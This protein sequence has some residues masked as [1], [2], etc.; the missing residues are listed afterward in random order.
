MAI[1]CLDCFY[2]WIIWW[3]HPYHRPESKILFPLWPN[4]DL[5]WHTPL[6]QPYSVVL[7]WPDYILWW[8]PH[9]GRNVYYGDTPTM[10]RP[11][12][13]VTPTPRPD[14][15]IWWHPY[16]GLTI[17]YGDAHTQAGLYN[18]VTPHSNF[19]LIG[20][21]M[22]A[23]KPHTGCHPLLIPISLLVGRHLTFPAFVIITQSNPQHPDNKDLMIFNQDNDC[24]HW[25]AWTEH[26]RLKAACAV[27]VTDMQDL[28]NKV[29]IILLSSHQ[30]KRSLKSWPGTM[31][32][33]LDLLETP[34]LEFQQAF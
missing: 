24:S 7:P 18:M 5:W 9:P 28:H 4:V 19:C 33:E 17:H 26:Q 31:R 10:A 16:P 6:A 21:N 20:H 12:T 13:M 27:E 1:I 30:L 23:W 2:S 15:S 8:C 11:Y 14:C 3:W 22:D 29:S 32:M 25:M 34:S